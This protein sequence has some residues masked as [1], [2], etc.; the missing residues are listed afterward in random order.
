MGF[1]QTSVSF[2]WQASRFS[3]ASRMACSF[4]VMVVWLSVLALRIAAISV[5]QA[6]LRAA[7]AAKAFFQRGAAGSGV[8][9]RCSSAAIWL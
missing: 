6:S 7:R 3:V 4:W 8:M 2:C 9:A 1:C 5:R